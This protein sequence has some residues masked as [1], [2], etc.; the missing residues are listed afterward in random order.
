MKTDL[1]KRFYTFALDIVSLVRHL[2]KEMA[3]YEIGRQLIR[4]GTSIAANYEEAK[5]GFSKDDFIYKINIAYKEARETTFWLK[6]LEDSNIVKC[7]YL[8]SLR[9]ESEEIRNILG[10]S[11]RTAKGNS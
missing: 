10:T 8:S 5:G 4:S 1:N 2:P 9:K 7:G 11:V 6:L 3:T